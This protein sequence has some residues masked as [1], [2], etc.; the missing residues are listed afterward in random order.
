MAPK[1]TP[2]EVIDFLAKQVPLM[3]ND[4]KT[5][6]QMK[7]GGSP[8]RIMNRSEVQEMWKARKKSLTTLLAGL[9]PE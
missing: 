4:K 9:K 8:V 3:F 6:G 5:L 1:G 2:K 7:K